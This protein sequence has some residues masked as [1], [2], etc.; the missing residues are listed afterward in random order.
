MTEK[1]KGGSYAFALITYHANEIR[2]TNVKLTM[3]M[4]RTHQK[5]MTAKTFFH[6][7]WLVLCLAACSSD[8]YHTGDGSLSYLRADFVEAAT[9]NESY[10]VSAL[11][12]D[13][14]HLQLARRLK[15]SW[16]T[17]P[18]SVYRALLYYHQEVN[19]DGSAHILPLSV[20]PVQNPKVYRPGHYGLKPKTDPVVF[21]SAWSSSNG[22]YVNF[23]LDVKTGTVD[24]AMESQVVGWIFDGVS[25]GDDGRRT[26]KLRLYHDQNGVPEYYS[27][28]LYISL[29]IPFIPESLTADDSLQ[30]SINTYEG[31]VVKTFS[32]KY[33]K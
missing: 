19:E 4:N 3:E 8:P 32:L 9:D 16:T 7:L 5:T 31:E 18:D 17:T 28:K 20:L 6:W 13:G 30:V 11:T 14:E 23:D 24:G 12:D 22:K 27:A 1:I 15:T 2:P 21:Q 33:L 29:S 10:V 26:A 25:Q